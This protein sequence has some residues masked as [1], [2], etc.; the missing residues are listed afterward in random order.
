[1]VLNP[2]DLAD[3]RAAH[4]EVAKVLKDPVVTFRRFMQHA[5]EDYFAQGC[6]C[7]HDCCGCTTGFGRAKQIGPRTFAVTLHMGLNV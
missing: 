3:A 7:S 6:A 4:R 2:Q 5:I 1:V